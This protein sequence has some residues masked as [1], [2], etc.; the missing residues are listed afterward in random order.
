M[1]MLRATIFLIT[2]IQQGYTPSSVCLHSCQFRKE[3][4][5]III[6]IVIIIIVV[7]VIVIIIII[8]IIAFL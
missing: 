7:I 5:I 3:I 2:V 8:I 4:I 1:Q 6:I